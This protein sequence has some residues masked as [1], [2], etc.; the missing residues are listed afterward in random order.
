MPC[1]SSEYLSEKAQSPDFETMDKG[2]LCRVLRSFTPRPA[3]RRAASSQQVVAHQHPQLPTA[4]STSPVLPHARPHQGPRA[5]QR[6]PDA[7]CGHPQSWRSRARGRWCRSKPSRAPTLRKLYTSSVFSTNTPFGLLN[8]V[9]FETCMYFARAAART[10]AGGGLLRAGH[11]RGW[12]QMST[13]S[14][15]ALPQVA[16]VV[17]EQEGA[18]SS[19]EENLPRMY[20]TAPSSAPMPASYRHVEAQPP[21]RLSSSG[22]G[23]HCSEGDVTWYENKAIGKNLLG[24]RMQMLSKA[25]KLSKTYTNHCIGAVL[26]LRSTA[27]PASVLNWARPPRRAA[28]CRGSQRGGSP[29]PH[30]PPPIPLPPPPPPAAPAGEHLYPP[31]R[32]P[33]RART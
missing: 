27:S 12:P 5:A 18:E 2:A 20:E 26:S 4:T 8:K 14:P 29:P 1:A 7:G 31:Q 13:S 10:T 25:A 6:Q 32:Q 33:G 9:W 19:D 23:D 17:V 30:Q 11:G 21:V 15:R 16:L 28:T 22:P 24:T 3:P